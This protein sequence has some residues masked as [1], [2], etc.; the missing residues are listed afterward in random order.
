MKLKNRFGVRVRSLLI[1]GLM[2]CALQTHG[3]LN[4]EKTALN[5]LEKHKYAQVEKT[6]Q[7]SLSKDTIN[8]SARYVY[9]RLWFSPLYV[10][11]SID[12]AYFYCVGAIQ[13]YRQLPAREKEK[14]ARFPIDS[15]ILTTLKQQIDSAAFA[16]TR[17]KDSEGAYVDFLN[18]HP[19]AKEVEA[20]VELR[21]EAAF[22]EADKSNTHQSY[23]EFI[24]K[25]PLAKRAREA[26]ARYDF[27]IYQARTADGRL[28]SY[29]SFLRDF[30][31]TP[32]HAEVEWK[33]LELST[34]SGRP[35]DWENFI[36]KYPKSSHVETARNILFHLMKELGTISQSLLTD[37]LRTVLSEAEGPLLVVVNKGKYGF[38]NSAG[39]VMIPATLQQ[40]NEDYLCQAVEDDFISTPTGVLS[41]RGEWI[42][43]GSAEA[44]ED[45]GAGFLLIETPQSYQVVH[46]SGRV[47]VRDVQD[48]TVI[49]RRAVAV[50]KSGKWS[51][52]S[53]IGYPITDAVYDEV[54]EREGVLV[55]VAKS[56][57]Y[58]I[59]PG[60]IDGLKS[61]PFPRQVVADELQWWAG[62]IWRKTGNREG[63]LSLKLTSELPLENHTISQAGPAIVVR[64]PVGYRITRSPAAIAST[65]WADFQFRP[66]WVAVR[67]E[68]RWTLW[69]QRS[70]NVTTPVD[71]LYW[72][73]PYPVGLNGDTTLVFGSS[74]RPLAFLQEVILSA[75]DVAPFLTVE[76]KARR[77]LYDTL[78]NIR[79]E[80]KVDKLA[81]LGEEVF[82]FDKQGQKGLM[83]AQGKV[84]LSAGYEAIVYIKDG[85]FSLLKDRLFGLY[86][87][88]RGLLIKPAYDRNL[89]SYARG[90]R[91]AFS[92]GYGFLT[93][94]G[95]PLSDFQWEEVQYWNDSVALVKKNFQWLLWDVRAQRARLSGI[96]NFQVVRDTPGE[97][98]VIAV[99]DNNAGVLSS[100]TGTLIPFSFSRIVN[101]G[102]ADEPLFQAQREVEE[103]SIH[104][105]I[106]YDSLGK[107][108][109]R[110]VL[111]ADDFEQ[112]E[113]PQR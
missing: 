31:G 6:L 19:D 85:L 34:L 21:N 82:L 49:A 66:P 59:L 73:G 47:L 93:T 95:H 79:F 3:Q 56:V 5:K 13:D 88:H 2:I 25:Y 15:T 42:W 8:P 9:A 26:Q 39:K 104:V 76:T 105:V 40:I 17:K 112:L 35:S 65:L 110:D 100:K 98:L 53:L 103:A 109:R 20:A 102:T 67:S 11:F 50:R 99:Q 7:K 61:Q 77:Y 63:L 70:G 84:L 87:H 111:E 86:D 60:E 38:I 51:I 94:D 92:G 83:N 90:I 29:E 113:C 37:S 78:G 55:L 43:K 30:P 101:L 36:R 72:E 18:T 10:D 74:R 24:D 23:R 57:K 80:I 108:V 97:K 69:N 1:A 12:S 4:P 96:R 32:Y 16:R 22:R 75:R 44:V 52:I 64:S 46:K 107:Q 33:I 106:Y 45:I 54:F 28:A 81:H 68:G 41:R 48:A 14:L 62:S 58:L 91:V 89:V 71:S 27:L